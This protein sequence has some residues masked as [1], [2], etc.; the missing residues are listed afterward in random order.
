MT[1]STL[2]L[3]N[4]ALALLMLTGLAA[5]VSLGLRVHRTTNQASHVPAA[6]T[7]IGL[8]DRRHADFARAA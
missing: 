1:T 8:H 6:P 5:V 7:P 3:M 2:V 4:G